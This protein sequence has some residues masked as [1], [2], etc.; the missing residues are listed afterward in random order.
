[1]VIS[2]ETNRRDEVLFLVGLQRQILLLQEVPLEGTGVRLDEGREDGIL[3]GLRLP[4]VLLDVAEPGHLIV[5]VAAEELAVDEVVLAADLDHRE[6]DV[7]VEVVSSLF[8]AQAEVLHVQLLPQ[9]V[10]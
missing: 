6:P 4:L 2:S 1:M 3:L 9:L 5:G 7:V 8:I 10:R